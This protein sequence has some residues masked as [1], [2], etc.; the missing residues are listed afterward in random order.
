[1]PQ[2][3]IPL[4]TF[5]MP[6]GLAGLAVTWTAAADVLA[7]PET[8]PNVLWGIAGVAWTGLIAAHI[9]RAIRVRRPLSAQLRHPVQGPTAALVP[10]VA[11]LLGARLHGALPL[12]GTVV[13]A[14]AIG[15]AA[16][17]AGWII[18]GWLR[19]APPSAV[20]GGY[21]LPTVASGLI[22]ATTAAQ[23]GLPQLAWGAFAVGM[24]FWLVLFA[25]IGMRL[26]VV[27]ALPGPLVPTMA[28]L[29]APPAVA[30]LAWIALTGEV[31]GPVID[32]LVAL[33]VISVL[34]QAALLP[35]YRATPF[36][37]GMWSFTFPFAAVATFF[38]VA[39]GFVPGLGVVVALAVVLAM[40]AL[41]GTVALL[42]LRLV[43]GARRQAPVRDGRPVT[44]TPSTT[45]PIESR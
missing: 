17:F 20:H 38:I 32:G 24:V 43:F 25:V 11:M 28:I 16:L 41:V 37:L 10:L 5:A 14:V 21:L 3:R 34:I 45:G 31:R 42:S 33:T 35:V 2:E 36:S 6:F 29:V 22:G 23:V 9:L 18:A 27:P 12:L 13:V 44:G 40:T 39:T 19:G 1:M 8:V 26:A 7:W 15:V 30:G 4:N